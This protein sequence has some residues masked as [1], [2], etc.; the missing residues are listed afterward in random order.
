MANKF[1]IIFIC[2]FLC[3]ATITTQA[4]SG[5]TGNLTWSIKKGTLTISGKGGMPYYSDEKPAPWSKQSFTSVVIE[6]GVTSI[7][8]SAFEECINLTSVTIPNSVT[9][10][11]NGAFGNCSSLTSVTIPNSVTTIGG[12]AFAGCSSLTSV[13]I[14]NSVITIG[15]SAFVNCS[16]T[17]VTIPNSV[18]T[19][20][21]DAFRGCSNL[22]SITIPNSVTSI[23]DDAF[24]D[25]NH[26][27][28]VKLG[29]KVF[30]IKSSD[31][32]MDFIFEKKNSYS[33]F[34]Q[35]YV[36]SE[37]NKWQ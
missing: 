32:N 3:S 4:Q 33:S 24:K 12:Y 28:S 34:A 22:I 27:T 18:T 20:G 15:N 8:P 36:E 6:N 16:I 17:S 13:K 25:C 26:L 37:I 21:Y 7:G 11:E 19:I 23:G 14:P 31:L 35:N 9:T 30:A 5:K 2:A 10:I 1:F 29:D